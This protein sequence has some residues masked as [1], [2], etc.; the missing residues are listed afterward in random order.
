MDGFAASLADSA[1]RN[2]AQLSRRPIIEW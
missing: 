2:Y 1:C